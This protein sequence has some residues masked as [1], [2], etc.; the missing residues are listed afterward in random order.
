MKETT[1]EEKLKEQA[2]DIEE[3]GYTYEVVELEDALEA[4]EILRREHKKDIEEMR[5]KILQ[6]LLHNG[7]TDE[8][9]VSL[10]SV[11]EILDTYLATKGG[12][13]AKEHK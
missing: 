6:L 8:T 2:Y 3:S 10:P 12:T 5:S 4:L 7:F 11:L 13:D 9:L 1:A